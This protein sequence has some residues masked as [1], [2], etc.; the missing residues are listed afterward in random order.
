MSK[1]SQHK[2]YPHNFD[3]NDFDKK[4]LE[5]IDRNFL[6]EDFFKALLKTTYSKAFNEKLDR[7]E[8]N[9]ETLLK[10]FLEFADECYIHGITVGLKIASELYD[11]YYDYYDE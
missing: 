3:L 9:R 11:E 5:K 6:N 8:V 7:P 10:K 1:K 2:K 4:I